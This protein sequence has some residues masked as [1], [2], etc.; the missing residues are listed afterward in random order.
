MKKHMITA[1]SFYL[2]FLFTIAPFP[3]RA[4]ESLPSLKDCFSDYFEFGSAMSV[5]E[6]RNTNRLPFYTSQY[7]IITPENALKPENVI[8]Q[9]NSAKA[10]KDDQG[11]VALAFQYRKAIA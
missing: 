9:Y 2:I 6:A 11:A 5:N 10:A 4:Q 7:S 1:V 8:D 3:A